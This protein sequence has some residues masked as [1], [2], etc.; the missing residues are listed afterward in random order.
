MAKQLRSAQ[1]THQNHIGFALYDLESERFLYEYNSDKYFTP[2]SNTK[3]LTFYT[4]L[5][6]IGDSIPGLQY[7]L[8]NDSLI[9]WGTGDPSL[10][11]NK[12]FTNDRV[13]DFLKSTEQS[14]YLSTANFYSKAFGAGWAWDDYNDTYSS[15]R[16]PLPVYGN[17]FTVEKHGSVVRVWPDYFDQYMNVGD[18]RER[19]DVIRDPHSNQFKFYPGLKRRQDDTWEI[20]MKLD[21]EIVGRLLADTLHKPVTPVTIQV[22]P[23]VRTV[24]SVPADSLYKTMMQES[25]NFIAEQLLLICSG[26]VRDSLMTEIVIDYSVRNFLNDLPDKVKW[27]D[28]SGL[29]RYN[30][31]T[32]R[33]IVKLWKKIYDIRPREKLFPL[34]AIGGETGTL[35]RWYAADQPYVFGK[36]GTLSNNHALSGYLVTK[37]GKILIFSFMNNNYLSS[38][39]EVRHYMQDILYNIYLN[40]K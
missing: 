25:D 19:E 10:L 31:I 5:R 32:P 15:E 2:A 33:S 38:V 8:R 11:Y 20:P 37:S 35:K 18:K 13:V 17:Y 30:L 22:H 4:S 6:I 39:N 34:L 28:G 29:S 27:V 3:I 7:I 23:L 26:I 14:I 24:F 12:T 16:S 9:I 36:T 40:Y 1:A 21:Q